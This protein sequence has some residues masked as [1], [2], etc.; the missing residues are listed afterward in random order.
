MRSS[1]RACVA[2]LAFGLL[3]AAPQPA[4]GQYATDSTFFELSDVF[5]L[6]YAAD[7]QIAP[8]GERVVYARSFMD[9]MKDR[10]ASRLWV[11]GSDGTGH[12]PIT[13]PDVRAS[14]PRWSPSGDRIAYVAATEGDGAEVYVRWMDTGQTARLT[15]LDASPSGLAWSPDGEHLAFSMFVEATAEPFAKMPSPPDGAD[16]A[17]SPDVVTQTYYRADGGG[18]TEKGHS[19]LFVLDAD[20]GT[21]RQLTD[22]PYDH[23]GAP[24]WTPDGETLLISAN[25]HD[26]HRLDPLN[27]EVYAVDVESGD[28]TALT[29]RQGPDGSVAISPDGETIA[30]TGFDDRE[31]GYQVTKLYAMNRDG[32]NRRLLTEG[33][34]RDVQNPTF[35]PNGEAIFFQ[36]DDEGSTKIGRITL[37]GD[38]SVV[39]EGVGGTSIGRPY[40]SGSFSLSET[41][42]VAFTHAT[43]QRPADVA[44]AAPGAEAQVLTSLND[45]LF[46][47]TPLGEVEEFTYTSSHDG[48]TIEGWIVKPPNFDPSK[49]YPLILEIHGGPF[50][51]YGPVFSTEVQLYAAAGY[52]VLY[53]N[54]RG[55]TSYGQDFGNAIHHAYPSH[56]YDDLMSGVDAVVER[57]YVDEDRLYVTGGSGGGVLT[58]WIVGHTDRFRAAVSAKPV[59][60]WVSWALTADMY[61]Y[62]VKYWFPGMPWNHMDH[63]MERS[64]ISY[65]DE[66]TT[67]TMLLTGTEDYRTPMSESEQFYQALKLQQVETALVRIPGASH[68]IAARPSQLAAKVAHVLEW[69]ERHE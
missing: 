62:G 27:S 9:K 7:P 55:S 56:D 59:I 24:V 47:Q 21:P 23:G 8:D 10:R 18:Y 49:D 5:D 15:Q 2:L 25:R 67:P 1:L 35:G 34:D 4:A 16:W 51:A 66:I 38:R 63:Y 60:N 53:T 30:Y 11:V 65:V 43:T 58:A 32:S 45:D 54:P 69:F 40:T 37:D 64:P 52:V 44:V 57:G 50:A 12:R 3:A 31:Q 33:F 20:G 68:G 46:G 6:E 42:R 13:E 22:A 29:D 41:G 48:R 36:Y 39:A 28:V 14:Q 61:P 26:D 17:E 19:Q